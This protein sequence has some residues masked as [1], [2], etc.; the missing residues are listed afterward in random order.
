MIFIVRTRY[1]V[2][3]VPLIRG[4]YKKK[5]IRFGNFLNSI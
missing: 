5:L 1:N 2:L 4:V 3:W